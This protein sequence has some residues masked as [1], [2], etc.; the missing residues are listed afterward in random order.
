MLDLLKHY[1]VLKPAIFYVGTTSTG[2]YNAELP[3]RTHSA[4][5]TRISTQSHSHTY[6]N[7]ISRANH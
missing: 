5:D 3:T 2:E 6:Y 1:P 4:L 7:L